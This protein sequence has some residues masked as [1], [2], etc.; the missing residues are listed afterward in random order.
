MRRKNILKFVSLLGI[1]SFV[2]LAAA[3]C[4]STPTPTPTPTPNPNP[5]D[6]AAARELTAARA[7]LTSLLNSKNINVEM[8]AD[9]AKIQ[10]ALKSAYTTAE[11]T[12]QNSSATLE[13]VKSATSNLQTAIDKAA[14][15][16]KNFDQSHNELLMAYRNLKTTVSQKSATV[17]SL[18]LS[19]PQY[20]AILKKVN[21][22]YQ[23][24]EK[25]L[26]ATLDPVS[27]S[28]PTPESIAQARNSIS[29]ETNPETLKPF[30][31][32]ADMFNS[33]QFYKL[34]STKLTDVQSKNTMPSNY[35]FV[36]YSVG[37]DNANW[38]FAQ[39]TVWTNGSDTGS[40]TRLPNQSADSAQATQPEGTSNQEATVTKPLTDVSW[41]YSLTG[42]NAKYTLKFTYYGPETGYLYFP[43]KLIKQAD[44]NNLGLQYKL[45]TESQPTPI[46]FGTQANDSGPAATVDSINIAKVMIPGLAFGENSIEFSVPANKV[47]P[48]I[49]NMYFTSN[50][51]SERTIYNQIFGNTESNESNSTVV[52]V[53]LLKG[54]GLAADWSTYIAEYSGAGLTLNNEN[55]ADEKFY[56]IGFVGGTSE[57]NIYSITEN[58]QKL[59]SLVTNQNSRTYTFYVNAP[60]AGAYY[61]K[62]VFT[63][64]ISRDLKF[65]TGDMFSNN[66]VTVKQLSTGNYSTITLKT[67]DTS[68][69]TGSTQVTTDPAD[70]KTLTLVEGLN[71]IVVSGATENMG[72][73]PNFGYLEFILNETQPETTNVSNPS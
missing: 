56:F 25:I 11:Q 6:E 4:T 19:N 73:A 16:K 22:S 49:G 55:K 36:G 24:A 57:R 53:N 13:Q 68:A 61:I 45:N 46:T 10:N 58:V 14:T 3:S 47:A 69:T 30:K 40:T 28:V 52:S 12:S 62:G 72:F 31:T 67:F 42:T 66:N 29:T 50:A 48:M 7:S 17:S 70:R 27:G 63:S 8:Y 64:G 65:S 38:S 33:Y 23:A 1:S 2:M 15:D 43:Y 34:D 39:R 35:S 60:K 20:S 18:G 51:N 21:A 5:G 71:K 54:Y 41:I 32:N 59:P 26:S 37:L 9:Y 44:S